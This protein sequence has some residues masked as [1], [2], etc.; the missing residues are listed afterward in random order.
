[1][2][3]EQPQAGTN[4]APQAGTPAVAAANVTPAQDAED[5]NALPGWAQKI[6]GEL[7]KESASH[8]KAKADAERAA[9]AQAEQAAKEQGKWQELAT[10]YEPKAKRTDALEKFIAD[11]VE[12][13]LKEV[14]AKMQ[15][16]VPSF[17]DPLK[18]LDWL[19]NAKAAG[20]FAPP[21]A[22]RTDA[23]EGNGA[24]MGAAM[25]RQQETI[26]LWR[27]MGF[28]NAVAAYERE[29]KQGR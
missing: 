24:G 5:V 22:P 3:D 19:R 10:Q 4:E 12:A 18:T 17:D 7:R 21:Q 20:M 25:A 13:E 6:I 1:M 26:E 2:A 16:L 27:Q 23:G 8:R 29:Q 28:N 9:Q 14:P 11:M 15:S